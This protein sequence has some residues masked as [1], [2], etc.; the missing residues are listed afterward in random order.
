MARFL[1]PMEKTPAYT[2][3][4]TRDPRNLEVDE[5]D[6]QANDASEEDVDPA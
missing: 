5:V 3:G 6:E 2:N 4:G 1:D